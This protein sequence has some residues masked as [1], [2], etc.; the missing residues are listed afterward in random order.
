MRKSILLVMILCIGVVLAQPSDPY[1]IEGLIT[2]LENTAPSEEC[3]KLTLVGPDSDTVVVDFD[4]YGAEYTIE[5]DSTARWS[6]T[7]YDVTDGDMFLLNLQDTCLREYLYTWQEVGDGHYTYAGNLR[8]SDFYGIRPVLRNYP[9]E[10]STGVIDDEFLFSAEYSH[11]EGLK[12]SILSLHVD[13]EEYEMM[14]EFSDTLDYRIP[15]ILEASFDGETFGKGVHEYYFYTEDE[16]GFPDL[17][18]TMTF[19]I[20]N[21]PPEQP[22]ASISPEMPFYDEALTVAITNYGDDADGDEVIY[23]YDWY[24]NGTLI[25]E[26][27]SNILNASY[28]NAGDEV[29]VVIAPFDGED[30]GIDTDLSVTIVSPELAAPMV[31]PESG[32]RGDSFTYSVE[33]RNARDIP[34]STVEIS[35]D[36]EERVPMEMADTSAPDWEAGVLY[37]YTTTIEEAGDHRYTFYAEDELGH[38]TSAALAGPVI[39]NEP[40]TDPV[41]SLYADPEPASIASEITCVIIDVEDPDDDDIEFIYTWYVNGTAL[42]IDS[43]ISTID[44]E[45]FEMGD[46]V[47]CEVIATDGYDESSAV[48]SDTLWIENARPNPPAAVDITP[49]TPFE[50]DNIIITI[51]EE[52]D[53]P[54]G[55]TIVSYDYR[56]YLDGELV[57]EGNTLPSSLTSHSQVWTAEIRSYDGIGYSDPLTIEIPIES[58]YFAEAY[59]EPEDGP[60]STGDTFLFVAAF[61]NEREYD[62]E[63][64][65][66][67][68]DDRDTFDIS[69]YEPPVDT[70]DDSTG[71]LLRYEDGELFAARVPVY[72]S[73]EHYFRFEG[74]D[75]YDNFIVDTGAP[76]P[77]PYIE[78]TEPEID[79]LNITAVPEGEYSRRGKL[80]AHAFASDIDSDSITYKYRWF[81]DSVRVEAPDTTDTLTSEHFERGDMVWFKAWALD[82]WAVSS[83]ILSDPVEITN[84]AP[85]IDHIQIAPE[86]PTTFSDL[87]VELEVSDLDEDGFTAE[88][89]WYKDGEDIGYS[90]DTV[91][92]E[93][94]SSEEIWKV[95]VGVYDGYDWTYDSAEVEIQNTGPEFFAEIT[96]TIAVNN[97]N[98]RLTVPARDP[99][100]DVLTFNLEDAPEGMEIGRNTG[101]INWVPD[102]EGV[103]NIELSADDGEYEIGLDFNIT[104]I[105]DTIDM[106]A[107]RN[108]EAVSGF[109]GGI[110][111]NWDEPELFDMVTV[112]PIDF[113]GYE[114]FRKR[115]TDDEFSS[116]AIVPTKGYFDDVDAVIPHIY[117]VRAIYDELESGFTDEVIATSAADDEPMWYSTFTYLRTPDIDGIFETGEWN[118]AMKKTIDDAT[119]YIKNTND[120]LYIGVETHSDVVLEDD[121]RL[122][123][124]IEDSYNRRYPNSSPSSEGEYR[125]EMGS[126]DVSVSFQGIWGRRHGD[127]GSD[128]RIE[129]RLIQGAVEHGTGMTT[130]STVVYELAIPIDNTAGLEPE[131]IGS[132]TG[133]LV[134][135]RLEILD[136]MSGAFSDTIA[137]PSGS[138]Q[139]NPESFGSLFLAEGENNGKIYANPQRE[140]IF[141]RAGSSGTLPLF[142]GNN[143]TGHITY[144]L[145]ESYL[146]FDPG[147]DRLYRSLEAAQIAVFCDDEMIGQA[148]LDYL[149]Y[150]YMLYTSESEFT[151]ALNDSIYS[152]DMAVVTSETISDE[153]LDALKEHNDDGGKVVMAGLDV[154]VENDFWANLGA[155]PFNDLGETSSSITFDE[156]DNLVFNM[157]N[158]IPTFIDY[159]EGGYTDFGEAMMAYSDTNRAIS[160]ASFDRIAYPNNYAIMIS[161]DE[162]I[163]MNTYPVGAMGDRDDDEIDDGVELIANEIYHAYIYNDIDWLSFT[164]ENGNLSTHEEDE[165][166]VSFDAEGME[167]GTYNGYIHV[168]SSDLDEPFIPI[169][170]IMHVGESEPVEI[171]FDNDTIET[172]PGGEF[173]IPIFINELAGMGID[174]VEFSVYSPGGSF[175][176]NAVDFEYDDATILWMNRDSVRIRMSC[177][178]YF[179]A[180][181][182]IATISYRTNVLAPVG[183]SHRLEIGNV[184]TNVED[185]AIATTSNK[186]IRILGG[187]LDWLVELEFSSH[188]LYDTVSFGITEGATDMYDEGIDEVN[189]AAESWFDIYFDI[190]EFDSM[191]TDLQKDMRSPDDDFIVWYIVTGD[192]AGK[193]EWSFRDEDTITAMGNLFINGIVDMKESSDYEYAAGETLTITYSLND[194]RIFTKEFSPGYTMFSVPVTN[195]DGYYIAEDVLPDNIGFFLYDNESSMWTNTERIYPGLGYVILVREPQT[196]E[197]SGTEVND[198]E[199]ELS[200]SWNLIGTTYEPVDFSEP[201]TDPDGAI[202]SV[203][204]E[205]YLWDPVSGAYT[206]S[207]DLTAGNAYFVLAN[208]ECNLYLNSDASKKSA[209]AVDEKSAII[210]IDGKRLEMGFGNRMFPVLPAMPGEDY[211][212]K[213]YIDADGNQAVSYFVDE[214]DV[215]EFDIHVN[216]TEEFTIESVDIPSEWTLT[217]DGK[218]LPATFKSSGVFKVE[219]DRTDK[220][221]S[222]DML[223]SY[224][225]PFNAKTRIDFTIGQASDVELGIYDVSG[226]LIRTLASD[227]IEKGDHSIFFDGKSNN[228]DNISTGVYFVRIKAGEDTAV[229]RIMLVK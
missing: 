131:Y 145:I 58:P 72:G 35:I 78:N 155:K 125:I 213:A 107:P 84:A 152:Y 124:S 27:E 159:I 116:I 98:Y 191:T 194:S 156:P 203:I 226:R 8:F 228:G 94:V 49:D 229:E 209:E 195:A 144:H 75:R 14:S 150:P 100:F 42:D 73:G 211:Q 218:E 198:L 163:I 20:E 41:I 219:I 10:P 179:H 46:Y 143:G 190:S 221:G 102:T 70:T 112:L 4:S 105:S 207:Y 133:N 180:A 48:R 171:S 88:Y 67:I 134:G 187:D 185:I 174:M 175:A 5:S 15:T 193:L 1:T 17:S 146:D 68:I 115:T 196:M 57:H 153:L 69:S 206:S 34:A 95:V 186:L 160:L 127:F 65:W 3:F 158:I 77:G 61:Y 168:H 111:L 63:D 38:P 118:D 217:V 32:E 220:P 154:P 149:G 108:L 216:S 123:V 9:V 136:A 7:V 21:T 90:N 25:D 74:Y 13:G 138:E 30:Y 128:P 197:I 165:I 45:Y 120:M 59:F 137:W 93:M 33:Y 214:A 223:S 224:P 121:D 86:L 89:T 200:D 103:F 208:E 130:D 55:D 140:E 40:P 99:D 114:I 36:G 139:L 37:E 66:L 44:A 199:L 166:T 51:T 157:P 184:I 87:T 16:D 113:I 47:F 97:N 54:D 29:L 210:D 104:V 222:I 43:D 227:F 142:I 56:W 215:A 189:S 28:F 170:C 101:I 151:S 52:A 148:A 96:D 117:K 173:E 12:P 106:L 178:D 23:T 126:E 83:P 71:G 110:P 183:I 31:D 182:Q 22:V 6:I 132:A 202:S 129:S 64:G 81:V 161:P 141:L 122:L 201:V 85:S 18:D 19:E 176:P 76:N 92:A 192:S 212:P 172:A 177:D 181:G 39:A 167:V 109:A 50:M 53:D 147:A 79:S 135:M 24:V 91:M 205:A 11:A 164:P 26:V 188:S 225:N 60:F 82:G 119:V 169:E 80:V 204:D 62:F 162:S 2:T